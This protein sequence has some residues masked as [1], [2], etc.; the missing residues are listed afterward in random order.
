MIVFVNIFHIIKILKFYNTI[1]RIKKMGK[2]K[3]KKKRTT[4][5]VIKIEQI[6]NFDR[7]LKKKK[8]VTVIQKEKNSNINQLLWYLYYQFRSQK[9]DSFTHVL[10]EKKSYVEKKAKKIEIVII[11]KKN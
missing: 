7:E 9:F 4:Q 3:K 1:Q 6:Y 8:I 5:G 11:K 2:T 10:L